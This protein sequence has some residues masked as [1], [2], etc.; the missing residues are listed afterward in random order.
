MKYAIGVLTMV[1]SLFLVA[2]VSTVQAQEASSCAT[3]GSITLRDIPPVRS[4]IVPSTQREIAGYGRA[5]KVGGCKIALVCVATDSGEAAREV[6]RQ[7]CVAV[8]DTLV[9]SGF[10]KADIATSR[11]NPG[12]G[13]PAGVVLF[14]VL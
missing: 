5:A 8:R 12:D 1:A 3:P 9:N 13:R 6:A 14:S 7:Q 11:Q 2:G 10:T 4:E